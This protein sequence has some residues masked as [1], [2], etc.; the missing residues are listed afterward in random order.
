MRRLAF[1]SMFLFGCSDTGSVDSAYTLTVRA[2]SPHE[3]MALTVDGVAVPATLTPGSTTG[4][5]FVVKRTFE[6][7]GAAGLAPS[8][9]LQTW[10]GNQELNVFDI[11]IAACAIVCKTVGRC[12]NMGPITGEWQWLSILEDGSVQD[13]NAISCRDAQGAGVWLEE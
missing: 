12:D 4:H 9:Y 5:E 10:N 13:D 11:D 8:L 1:A 3:G 7:F 2:S 6:S